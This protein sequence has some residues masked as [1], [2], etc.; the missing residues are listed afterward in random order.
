M[1]HDPV[2]AARDRVVADAELVERERDDG[3]VVDVGIEVV[4]VL[5]RPAARGEAGVADR[6]VALDRDLLAE[7]VVAGLATSRMVGGDA[8]GAQGE[9]GER[10]VPDRRLARLG[11]Q[12][13]AVLDDEA[14]PALDCLAER[15]VV[16]PVPERRERDDRPHPRRLDP[17]PRAVRL[18]PRADPLLGDAVT[19]CGGARSAGA[20]A[21]SSR[22]RA[23]RAQVDVGGRTG[24][25]DCESASATNV[26]RAQQEKS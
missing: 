14:L 6:P 4:L 19:L 1:P 10:R 3:R 12:P 25:S 13:L 26:W 7:E 24:R 11:P 21:A 23:D 8:A 16:E 2:E 20:A 5:E 9:R 15:R 18:L 22:D 17:A